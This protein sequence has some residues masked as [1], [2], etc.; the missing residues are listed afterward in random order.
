MAKNIEH[1]FQIKNQTPKRLGI[2]IFIFEI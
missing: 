1:M 2:W